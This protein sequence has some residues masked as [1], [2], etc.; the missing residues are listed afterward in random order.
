MDVTKQAMTNITADFI[1]KKTQLKLTL[2]GPNP[3]Y[4]QHFKFIYYKNE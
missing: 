1:E 3:T 4:K 2:L